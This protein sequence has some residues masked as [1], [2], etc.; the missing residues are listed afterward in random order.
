[1]SLIDDDREIALAVLRADLFQ[2][3]G[4]LLHRRN[5]DLLAALNELSKIARVFRVADRRPYLSKLLDR[6][7][8][9]LVKKATIGDY[10]DGVEDGRILSSQANKLVRKP[11]DGI[12]FPT[13][14]GMLNQVS[15]SRPNRLRVI[16]EFPHH[17]EL[18]VAG[19]DLDRL[20]LSCLF[21]L[22][23]HYLCVVLN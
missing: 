16:Y 19:K 15:L 22:L 8:N 2:D 14:C 18:V 11:C 7:P 3:E 5:D 4:K 21:V 9:L 10:D 20:L 17:I 6:V 23:L 13:T 12:R 1:M